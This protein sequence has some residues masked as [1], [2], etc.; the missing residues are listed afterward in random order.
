MKDGM[1]KMK[2]D[3]MAKPMQKMGMDAN[4]TMAKPMKKMHKKMMK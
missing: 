4:D 1:N 2:K 3:S